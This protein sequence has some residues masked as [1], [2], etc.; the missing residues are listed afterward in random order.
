[1]NNIT[2]E[3]EKIIDKNDIFP[4]E[5]MSKHTSF[6]IGG[7][8]DYFLKIRTYI[9]NLTFNFKFLNRVIFYILRYS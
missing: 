7:K 2:E 9:P 5:L 6:K 1:M 4:N 8:A 3:L